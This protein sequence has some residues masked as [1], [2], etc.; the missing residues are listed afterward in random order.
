MLIDNYESKEQLGFY[1]FKLSR[2]QQI[3]SSTKK[4]KKLK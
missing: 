4:A 1:I 2:N 3:L